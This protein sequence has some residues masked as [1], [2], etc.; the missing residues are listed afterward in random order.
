[1][2]DMLW[3]GVVRHGEST[4]NVAAGSAERDRLDLIDIAEREA[5]V[6]LSDLG[7]K[8]AE[9]LGR[10]MRLTPGTELP[11]LVVVSPFLRARQ[12]AEIA[13]G[14][15]DVRI[16]VDERLRDRDLGVLDLHTVQG[17]QARFPEESARRK[18]HGKFYYR[19]PGGESWADVALRLRALLREIEQDRPG[20]RIVLFAH[21]VVVSTTRYVLEDLEEQELMEAAAKTPIANA[22]LSSW[23]RSEG[24]WRCGSFNDVEHL[25]DDPSVRPTAEEPADDPA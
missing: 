16:R 22:S 17:I 14:D 19:P 21:D 8:Q 12:T 3:L 5:D 9:S 1:M 2:D 18:R 24:I 4:A 25:D 20:R 23:V 10:R 6:P 7:R 11:D 15:L 13:M